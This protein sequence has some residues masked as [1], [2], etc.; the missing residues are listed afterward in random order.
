MDLFFVTLYRY[1][2][3]VAL[4]VAGLNTVILWWRSRAYIAQNPALAPGYATLL[5]GYFVCLSLPW[6]VMGVGVVMGGIP[7]V[8]YFF[9][10]RTGNPYVIAWW[11]VYWLLAAFVTY[12]IVQR[13]GAEM[14]VSHPGFLRGNP[15]NPKTVKLTW[16]VL[17]AGSTAAI[18]IAAAQTPPP[19]LTG[20]G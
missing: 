15:T 11:V 14:L 19:S 6:V 3:L 12:W 20:L 18:A 13:G 4:V 7:N 5:R 16:L 2:W 1:F 17:L 8:A 9:Y 10:P